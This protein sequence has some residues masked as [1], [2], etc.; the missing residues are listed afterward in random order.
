MIKNN[1]ETENVWDTLTVQIHN[2]GLKWAL[3]L[4]NLCSSYFRL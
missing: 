2:D 4:W 3:K 1:G